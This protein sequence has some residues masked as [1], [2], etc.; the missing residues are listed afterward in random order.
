[1]YIAPTLDTLAGMN[2]GVALPAITLAFGTMALLLL[3]LFVPE[4]RKRYVP[5]AALSLISAS[6]IMTLFTYN[7]ENP[8][9]FGGM[10]R[11]DSFTNFVNLATLI[12]AFISIVI[13]TDYLRDTKTDHNE[14]YTLML[15]SAAGVMF[16]A[17][18]NDLLMVF[19]ALELLS[20]PLYI[21]AAF[22][23]TAPET[24]SVILLKSEESG[25]KYFILGAFASA[26]FVYGAAL[27]Y[28]AT[29]TTNLN[30]I[31]VMVQTIV[32]VEGTTTAKVLMLLGTGLVIVGLGFKVAA[33]PFHM[34]TPDVYE[35][36]PTP[37]TAF[38]SVAAKIGGFA[39]ILR[40]MVVGLSAF[41]LT[42]EQPAAWQNAVQVVAAL[43]LILGNT[44]ALSQS[45]I[46]RMLAYSSIAHAGY[47]LMGVAAVG[48]ANFNANLPN[49]S[50]QASLMYL[51]AYA[52]TTLGAFAVVMVLE[53]ADGR[54]STLD[55]FN[56]L[57]NTRPG[58][59]IAMTIFMLS[60]TGIPLTAGFMGKWLV[61]NATVQ[62]GLIPLAIIGVI[63]SVVSA[64]YYLRVVVNMFLRPQA[65]D[66]ES[67]D[68]VAPISWSVYAS[69]TAVMILG[70]LPM[71]ILNNLISVVTLV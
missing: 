7:P 43:T 19:I 15:L 52:F 29:G 8:V 38:M 21:M 53:K 24:D 2:L 56:G 30:E 51:A 70:I 48:S 41:S 62:A 12:T 61:F 63:T 47:L 22:R 35:G 68:P 3:G 67:T 57:Y 42:A 14:Y 45:N 6:F 40:I 10:F 25:I 13:S 4:E 18:A 32:A 33:V 23:A 54:G 71:L 64:F 49:I 60:L 11:G 50:V 66:A 31:F 28:G 39:S 69:M 17:G 37:V 44:V 46:K 20:I 1:M 27:I 9:A 58:M 65:A 26:F 36:A 34:W 16:M 55:D 59:A 5:I